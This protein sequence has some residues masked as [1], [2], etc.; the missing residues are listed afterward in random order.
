MGVVSGADAST[1]RGVSVCVYERTFVNWY[2][3]SLCEEM[4]MMGGEFA[5]WEVAVCVCGGR[6]EVDVCIVRG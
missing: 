2:R 4:L 3:F 6:L 1:A 5:G